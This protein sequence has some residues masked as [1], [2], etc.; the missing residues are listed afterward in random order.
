M[1]RRIF[2]QRSV[3]LTA[4]LLGVPT[5]GCAPEPAEPPPQPCNVQQVTLKIFASDII[6]QN[7]QDLPRPVVVRL[8][9]LNSD[10]K[11]QNAS[12]DEIL[13][14]DTEI[15]GDDLLARD[16]IESVFP[17]DIVEV[18][19]E[20]IPEASFLA[21]AALFQSPQGQSWKTFYAFPPMP[22]TPE[23]CGKPKDGEGE[24]KKD[25]EPQAF[26][27]TNFFVV[28][29]KIDNGASYD[30]TM[31]PRSRPVRSLNLPKRSASPEAAN[32]PAANQP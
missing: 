11:M 16:E 4:P 14:K 26:P 1:N 20:R 13:E 7:D 6:N 15:L 2:L 18:K 32:T 12:Y 5:V 9:Q 24:K 8:Y 30:E 28:E 21:A 27:E 29:R 19:F 22:N 17:N 10:L 31:F 23:A 25:S 3:W